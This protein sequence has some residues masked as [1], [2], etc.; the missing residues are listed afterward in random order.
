MEA[1]S[2][3]INQPLKSDN[4]STIQA[5]KGGRPLSAMAKPMTS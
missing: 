2:T 5:N 4:L 1:F 3:K